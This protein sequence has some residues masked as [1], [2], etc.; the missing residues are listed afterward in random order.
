MASQHHAPGFMDLFRAALQN[1]LQVVKVARPR[2]GE[3][4]EGRK[5][6]SAHG[7]DIAKGN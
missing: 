4:G 6:L 7:I 3:N 1:L 5:R 2:P